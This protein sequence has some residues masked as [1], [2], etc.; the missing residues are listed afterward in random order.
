[1]PQ[2]TLTLHNNKGKKNKGLHSWKELRVDPKC[3][4]YKN[5]S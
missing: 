2:C 5:D 1:M 4:Q 3:F